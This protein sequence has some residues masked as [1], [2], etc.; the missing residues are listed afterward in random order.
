MLADGA[1]RRGA[2]RRQK[3]AYFRYLTL[4]SFHAFVKEN[5]DIVV[6]E[7]GVGG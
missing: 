2:D 7:V 3:P 1:R 6:Y 4:L 5:V